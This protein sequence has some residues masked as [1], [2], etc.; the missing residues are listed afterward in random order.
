MILTD[1]VLSVPRPFHGVP[2]QP[3]QFM[4]FF[5]SLAGQ[6][7]ELLSVGKAGRDK[8]IQLFHVQTCEAYENRWVC[9]KMLCTPKPNG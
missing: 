1:P 7:R 9:L 5:E 6:P 2:P 8:Q 4:P 3:P